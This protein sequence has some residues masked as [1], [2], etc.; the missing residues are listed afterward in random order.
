MPLSGKIHQSRDL[1]NISVAYRNDGLIADQ[2]SPGVPV[3]HET[4]VF[5]VYSKDNFR[6]NETLRANGAVANEMDWDVSTASYRLDEHAMRHLVTDR[7]R[8]N[9]DK[10]IR[11]DIDATE[12]LTD[13]ILLRREIDMATQA[14]T[15][16][17]W[18]N[19]TSLTSTFAWSANTTLSNPITFVD[20]AA[21]SVIQR[22][23]KKPN[24]AV[25]D[26]RTFQACK[27]H[28]SVVDRVKYTSSDS[29]TPNMLAKLFNIQKL[30]V[31]SGIRN[32]G[33]EGLTDSM[34]YIWTDACFVG[35]VEPSPGLKKPSTFYTFFS[36]NGFGN[37]FTVGRYRDDERDGDWVQVKSLFD[38]NT[39][40]TDTAY[41]IVNTI[42]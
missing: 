33:E 24:T 23:G 22:S 5:Y 40:A 34:G 3:K 7:D 21:T 37:P 29:V 17:N 28:I 38:I 42:Q 11:L 36:K 18:A 9:S 26:F 12:T 10:A 6:L 30:L 32:T 8:S 4:D 13:Q 15:A 41:L 16:A 35:Y 39:V 20:S 31:A 1:E 2:L 14:F 27:E 19:T 25:V